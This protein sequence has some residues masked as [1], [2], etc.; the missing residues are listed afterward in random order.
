M[1]VVIPTSADTEQ[2][3]A[4]RGANQFEPRTACHG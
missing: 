2:G 3:E 4:S 1:M